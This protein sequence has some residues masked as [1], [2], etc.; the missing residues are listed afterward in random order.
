MRYLRYKWH[1]HVNDEMRVTREEEGGRAEQ[2]GGRVVMTC[3]CIY[4]I[5]C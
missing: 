5:T 1:S 2:N 3:T 4:I